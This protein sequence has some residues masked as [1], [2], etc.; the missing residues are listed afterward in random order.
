MRSEQREALDNTYDLLDFLEEQFHLRELL[1]LTDESSLRN[2]LKIE[3]A[4]FLGYLAA[5]DGVISWQECHYINE[6]LDSTFSPTSLNEMIIE[7]DVYSTRF[8][9][10]APPTLRVAVTIDNVI[11]GNERLSVIKKE[12][13]PVIVELY[14]II[15]TGLIKANGRDLDDMDEEEERNLNVYLGMMRAYIDDNSD[16]RH[17]DVLTGYKKRRDDDDDASTIHNGRTRNNG[18][19]RAPKKK[20]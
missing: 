4:L 7:K 11:Y 8:E 15:A 12:L 1:G 17:I 5:S 14:R 13:G 6:L 16:R 3:L 2:I 9:K 19:V 10:E 20:K 18:S